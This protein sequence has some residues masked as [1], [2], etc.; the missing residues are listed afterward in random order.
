MKRGFEQFER[1]VSFQSYLNVADAKVDD[2][3]HKLLHTAP[4]LSDE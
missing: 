4:N 1:K 2:L 3:K